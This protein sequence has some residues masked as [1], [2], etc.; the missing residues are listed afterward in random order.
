MDFSAAVAKVGTPL[1]ERSNPA[2]VP[3]YINVAGHESSF[4]IRNGGPLIGRD[5][6]GDWWMQWPMRA[7]A[8][9]AM[10]KQ[11]QQLAD[12]M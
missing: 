7:E 3:S 10:E 6:G 9:P 11:F 8:W 12:E 5:A 4:R 1:A 2:G